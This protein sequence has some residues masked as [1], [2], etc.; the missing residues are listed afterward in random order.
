MCVIPAKEGTANA[1]SSEA[2]PEILLIGANRSSWISG[3]PRWIIS[4]PTAFFPISGLLNITSVFPCVLCQRETTLGNGPNARKVDGVSDG[5]FMSS[6]DGLHWDRS[7]M[8]AFIRPGLNPHNW[9][10]AIATTHLPGEFS[11][12]QMKNCPSTGLKIAATSPDSAVARFAQMVL[13]PSMRIIKATSLSPNRWCLPEKN[14]VIN[15]STSS[16]G[17][18]KVVLQ[19]SSGK[20]IDG[21]NFDQSDEIFGDEIERVVTWSKGTDISKHAGSPVKLQFIMKDA[22]LYSFRFK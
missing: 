1:V 4:I 12:P 19:D 21:Y 5:V 9:G 17:Y 10:K 7:F 8:E 18:I 2:N 22:D 6:T 3:P 16:V 20:T 14:F 11:P 15:Y 13:F